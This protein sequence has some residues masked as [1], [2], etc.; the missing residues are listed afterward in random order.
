MFWVKIQI[1]V[2]G[3]GLLFERKHLEWQSGLAMFY[4]DFFGWDAEDFVEF[5]S[6]IRHFVD[7]SL[8]SRY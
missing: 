2:V 7:I 4:A 8:L 3:R 5:C 1:L 6:T